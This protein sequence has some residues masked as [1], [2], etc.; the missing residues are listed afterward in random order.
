MILVHL[1]SLGNRAYKLMSTIEG[2]FQV[3]G[4]IFRKSKKT[5]PVSKIAIRCQKGE[6]AGPLPLSTFFVCFH[7]VDILVHLASLGERSA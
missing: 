1:A 3:E 4:F 6:E 2:V 7:W 5:F